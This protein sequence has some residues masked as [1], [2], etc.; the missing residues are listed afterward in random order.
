MSQIIKV[1]VAVIGAGSAGLPAR[2]MAAKLGAKT[3]LIDPGPYGTTCARV[4][5]MPSKL[6]IAAAEAAHAARHGEVFGVHAQPRVDGVAVMKRV[7]AERDRFAGFVIQDVEAMPAEI[8]RRTTAK[9]IGP[10]TL[11][12]GDG[13]TVEAGAIV[14][15][16]G[17]SSWL[18]PPLRGLDERLMYNDDV[19][20]LE[21]LPKRLAVVGCGVIGIEL[22]QAMHRLGVDTHF[23][24][25]D[26]IIGA[27]TDPAVKA[28]VREA[29]EGSL[30]MKLECQRLSAEE[31]EGGV[32]VRWVDAEGVAG[33]AVFDKLLAATGRRP[34][35]AGLDLDKAGLELDR[36]V[37]VFDPE[38]MRCGESRVFLA[39]DVTGTLPLLH[40]ASDEG[41]IAGWN[42]ARVAKG[43]PVQR[44]ARRAPMGVV[45]T[46][47]NIGSAGRA[48]AS[49]K[50]GTFEIGEVDFRRQGRARVMAQGE[51][52]VRI[53]GEVG[54]GKLLG[55][56]MFGPR[57]ENMAHLLAWAIQ[58]G[59]TVTDALRMPFYHPVL[60][61]GLR[62]ALRD[63]SEKLG[64]HANEIAPR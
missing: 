33:E 26:D 21:D 50:P 46:D 63:L 60:E 20:D 38:T 12:L 3:L 62:T 51:G 44:Y 13:T 14:I 32:K 7:R 19:F 55:A 27:G 34:N 47:P 48:F 58:Q 24:A 35:V 49:L 25:V 31:V 39:G 52:L 28:R 10:N 6:L 41:R 43:E 29:F 61:E 2:R 4:G 15:A 11:A 17:S 59:L 57:V 30:N 9:F 45:F 37:P 40:E 5:C 64:I 36:G 8:L 16:T 56:E 23:F 22:G 54:T 53:Y 18:P 42:A 1:D